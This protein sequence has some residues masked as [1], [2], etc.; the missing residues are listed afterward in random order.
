MNI[1]QGLLSKISPLP[2]GDLADRLNYSYTSTILLVC[3]VFISGWSFVGQPIQCWFP[4]Y[5]RGWW[6]EY[7]LDY[8]Y[9]QNTYFVGFTEFKPD[10]SNAFDFAK[11][12]IEIPTNVTQRDEKQIGYYQWV[13]FILAIQAFCFYLP[14]QLWRTIYNT[15]GFRVRAI[16][17]TCNIRANMDPSDRSKNIETVARFLA[18]DHELASTLGGRIRQHLEGRVVLSTYLLIKFI[19]AINALLQFLI[20][21]WLL[22]TDSIFWGWNVV[23]DL[24]NGHEWPET[25]NFPRVTLC[26]FSVRV[27]GNLHN[28]TLQCVLMINMFNEKIFMFLWFWFL[29][30][31]IV[32]AYSLFSWLLVSFSD[33]SDRHLIATYLAKIDPQTLRS[34]TKK[35]SIKNF[36]RH[37]LRADGVFLVRL[38]AKNSGDLV[39]C[40]LLQTLWK[41]YLAQTPPPQYQP[42]PLIDKKKGGQ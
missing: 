30:M 14:V 1:V 29:F 21:K 4:A 20:V 23:V 16:C 22:G 36:V 2:D 6:M 32:T 9:V 26:D 33:R 38:I 41:D 28:H 13:H 5:Y 15:I 35:E 12:V 17:E 3:S 19:Y 37:T 42:E 39:T 11:H 27:L 18:S 7:A 25:G 8:C 24:W 40:E 10:D 31:A 34:N